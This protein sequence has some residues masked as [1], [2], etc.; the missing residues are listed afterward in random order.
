MNPTRRETLDILQL[1]L[2]SA[3]AIFS[4]M[5]EIFRPDARPSALAVAGSFS[6]LGLFIT[7]LSFPFVVVSRNEGHEPKGKE[8]LIKIIT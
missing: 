2:L 8:K 3:G 4:V 6:W 5:V 7:G 1:F